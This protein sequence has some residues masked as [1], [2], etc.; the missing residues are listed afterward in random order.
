MELRSS[1]NGAEESRTK[2]TAPILSPN[3]NA[4]CYNGEYRPN[5]E[6]IST[7]A[8][9]AKINKVTT[10]PERFDK[11]SAARRTS[12]FE[13][14]IQIDAELHKRQNAARQISSKTQSDIDEVPL[15]AHA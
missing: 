6:T 9:P 7:V 15:K 8:R 10:F 14:E 2:R 1:C 3:N 13:D 11:H 5:N 4:Q 12:F